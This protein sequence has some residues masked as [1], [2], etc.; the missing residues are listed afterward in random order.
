V[1]LRHRDRVVQL[2]VVY[3]GPAVGGKTTNLQ[4]LHHAALE[5][6]RGE[7]ISVNSLQDRTILFDLLPLR[8]IGFHGFEIRFQLIAVPGQAIYAASRRLAVR[9][10]DAVVF[11]A[12]S[13]QDRLDENVTSLREM[14]ANLTESGLDPATIPMVFQYNKRDLPQV[15]RIE[16]L[17]REVNFRGAEAREAVAIRGDGVLETLGCVLEQTMDDLV[18]RYPGLALGPGETTGNWTWSA[19]H[20]AFGKTTLRGLAV[21][22]AEPE[23]GD[24][25]RRV[26]VSVPRM[27]EGPSEQ[28]AN[29][30]ALVDSYVQASMD[31]GDALERMREERDEGR[32]RLR[33]LERVLETVEALE[34]GQPTDEAMGSVL[35]LML[36]AAGCRRGSLVGPG[37]DRK[38]HAIAV[39]GIDQD[40]FLAAPET[41]SIARHR[42]IPL[43]QPL[44]ANPAQMPDVADVLARMT[45]PVKGLTVVPVRSGLGVHGL[46]LLYFSPTETLP[47]PPLLQHFGLLA[48]G[49]AS[50]FVLRRG[51]SLSTTASAVRRALPEIEAAVRSA[52][53]LVR[54][55][56]REP[57]LARGLLDQ[58]ASVLDGIAMLANGLSKD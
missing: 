36:D 54:A 41:L 38:V 22:A 17:E 56:H 48:R 14:T 35:Q 21:P 13:A 58:T 16:D 57:Q 40:P 37:A 49:L 53:E 3:Y 34:S 8:G 4:V 50:W 2:K 11:V 25:H 52:A 51:Q 10:A 47:P 12:N 19:I 33:D 30:R 55:A 28:G 20:Q 44:L 45:P 46:A 39:S 42:F 9:G 6:N 1:E 43:R 29:D 27:A 23:P 7:F 24:D 31:L 5:R 26:R 15:T 32:R 18:L